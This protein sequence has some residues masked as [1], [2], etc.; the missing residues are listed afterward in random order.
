MMEQVKKQY[1]NQNDACL[2]FIKDFNN[3]LISKIIKTPYKE[4]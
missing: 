3:E 2:Y 1:K 4:S